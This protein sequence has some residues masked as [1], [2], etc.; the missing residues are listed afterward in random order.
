MKIKMPRKFDLKSSLKL[1]IQLDKIKED[2]EYLFDYSGIK[3]VEPFALLLISSKVR[4]FYEKHKKSR[5]LVKGCSDMPYAYTMGYFKS[6]NEKFSNEPESNTDDIFYPITEITKKSII[7]GSNEKYSGDVM[8][9]VREDVIDPIIDI[10]KCPSTKICDT[11]K[12]LLSISIDNILKHSYS[13]KFFVAAQMWKER[14]LIEFAIIDEGIGIRK[15]LGENSKISLY[16]KKDALKLA[17]W[18]GV[19]KDNKKKTFFRRNVKNSDGLGLYITSNVFATLGDYCL[20]SNDLCLVRKDNLIYF[21]NTLF[22]GT[23][24]RMRIK[25]S[26]LENIIKVYNEVA[27]KGKEE[28]KDIS[29]LGNISV[30]S[31]NKY[32]N[33]EEFIEEEIEGM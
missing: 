17:I 10:L 16:N 5:I 20:C 21:D 30:E 26:N 2:K 27:M 11:L 6:I 28:G 23:A 1:C 22:N 13:E 15:S 32:N 19:T 14:D 29:S 31:V 33:G 8:E 24:V 3:S 18:P 12:K 9:Y 4:E 25:I 7:K